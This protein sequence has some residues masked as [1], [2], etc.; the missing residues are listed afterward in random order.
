M[1]AIVKIFMSL[2]FIFGL[3]NATEYKFDKGHSNVEFSVKHLMITNVKGQFKD[4]DIKL[5]FDERTK[6]INSFEGTA[7]V[8]SIDTGIV[9]RDNHLK[10]DDFFDEANH[11]EML[12]TMTSY[13][14]NGDEG[15]ITGNLTI[16]GTTKQVVFEVEDIATVIDFQNNTRVGFTMEGK[17]NRMDYGLTWNKVLET[18]GIAVSETVKITVD[19]QAILENK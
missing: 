3:V 11:P 10:S 9:K 12:F 2:I 7:K 16:R 14:A 4:F 19:V 18:G 13:K 6:T 8:Y 17:I 1:K 5:D 15:E